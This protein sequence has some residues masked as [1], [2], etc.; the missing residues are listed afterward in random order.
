MT[1]KIAFSVIVTNHD[2]ADFVGAAIASVKAQ[3]WGDVECI[4]VDDGSTDGSRDVIEAIPGVTA[5]FGPNQGQCRAAARGFAASRGDV[6]IFLDADDR[7]DPEACAA[8][9]AVWSDDLLAV[10]YR[11]RLQRGDVVTDETLPSVPF[12]CDEAL[13]LFRAS[14]SFVSAPTSGN[15]FARRLV[16]E[17]FRTGEGMTA[18][19]VDYWL[20]LSALLAGPTRAIDRALGA[21]RI[22]GAN[23]SAYGGR[24]SARQLRREIVTAENAQ[25]SAQ[26]I[27]LAHGRRFT[28]LPHV[29]GAYELK[30][31]L[32]LRGLPGGD[33]ALPEI[34]LAWAAARAVAAFARLEGVSLPRRLANI[35]EV[36]ALAVLPRRLRRLVALRLRGLRD[37]PPRLPEE[38]SSA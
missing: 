32:L 36:I 4:V 12:R 33:P 37:D 22:H 30:W 2:Y 26:R 35:A 13:A 5:L 16:D 23:I 27:A 38:A 19:A 28:P 1:G 17:V 14:G 10:M 21:Y 15:A 9:A 3:T 20:C 34:P 6:V 18:N 25:R 31:Y 7:L 29:A 8:I 24:R 11:L